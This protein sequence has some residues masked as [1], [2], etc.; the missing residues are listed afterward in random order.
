M[1]CWAVLIGWADL[2]RV[3]LVCADWLWVDLCLF[4]VVCE[5]CGEGRFDGPHR[6]LNHRHV[7]FQ[8]ITKNKK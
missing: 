4:L 2:S 5:H 3:L 1:Y 7:N 6:V 8:P